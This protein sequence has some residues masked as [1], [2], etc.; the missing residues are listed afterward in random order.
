MNG[1][2]NVEKTLDQMTPKPPT[3]SL[4]SAADALDVSIYDVHKL[5]KQRKLKAWVVGGDICITKESLNDL[6]MEGD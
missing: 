6:L 1:K 3:V 2:S 5:I 4:E